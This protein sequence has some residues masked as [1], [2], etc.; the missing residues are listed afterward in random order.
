MHIFVKKLF[1]GKV[2][3]CS[4]HFI[5]CCAILPPNHITSEEA[6]PKQGGPAVSGP[7]FFAYLGGIAR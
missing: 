2:D 1:A 3:P 6:H 4:V 7:V 5:I